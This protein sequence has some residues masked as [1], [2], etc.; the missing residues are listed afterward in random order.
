[1]S[2]GCYLHSAKNPLLVQHVEGMRVSVQIDWPSRQLYFSIAGQD[3][4]AAPNGQGQSFIN[5]GRQ[6][7]VESATMEACIQE[8]I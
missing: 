8:A 6:A 2:Y 7:G 3:W 4:Q 1:M 5:A